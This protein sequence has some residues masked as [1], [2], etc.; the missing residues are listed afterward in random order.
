MTII[1][2]ALLRLGTIAALST[3]PASESPQRFS[4]HLS[5]IGEEEHNAHA[6]DDLH[7][8][9]HISQYSSLVPPLSSDLARSSFITDGTNNTSR[10]SGL[11]DFPVPP[12]DFMT[13][14][15]ASI[16]NSYF[17]EAS[18]YHP[19]NPLEAPVRP[20][21]VREPSRGTFGKHQDVGEAF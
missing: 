7:S 16:I 2:T 9:R 19:Q 21:L 4:R 17:S 11:S 8:Q 12:S 18:D 15:H 5:L 1:C 13:P 10:M 3:P 14:G 20:T 6:I